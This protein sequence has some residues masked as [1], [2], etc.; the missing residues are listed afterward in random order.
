MSAPS[1]DTLRLI[2]SKDPEGWETREPTRR[3]RDEFRHWVIRVHGADAW[4]TYVT[5]GWDPAR[6]GD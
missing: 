5:G 3:D 4:R 1:L 6:S 2:E